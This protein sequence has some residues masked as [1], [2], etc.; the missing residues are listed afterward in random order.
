MIPITYIR[1][2]SLKTYLDCGLRFF[3]DFNL[4]LKWPSGP[5]AILGSI[6]HEVQEIL[7][8]CKILQQS[9]TRDP[10]DNKFHFTDANKGIELVF[11]DI[12]E[13]DIE[14]LSKDI[15]DRWCSYIDPSRIPKSYSKIERW[16]PFK[17]V[18]DSLKNII[19]MSPRSFDIRS[20]DVYAVEKRFNYVIPDEWARY[21]F[22]FRNKQHIGQL[23]IKGSIDLIIKGPD[24]KYE[25]IDWKSGSAINFST[26]QEKSYDDYCND[27]QLQLYYLAAK[28][29]LGLDVSQ[30]TIVYP[31]EK[32]VGGR[33][34][35]GKSFSIVFENDNDIIN[36]VRSIYED[37]QSANRP[38]RVNSDFCIK[39]CPYCKNT[40][41]AVESKPLIKA[42]EYLWQPEGQEP[43]K[44]TYKICGQL[45]KY[46]DVG[47]SP[48]QVMECLSRDSFNIGAYVNS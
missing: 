47:F 4:G 29:V 41:D 30:V 46:F 18:Q 7:G 20:M 38:K 16:I 13:I 48:L 14:K 40:F 31:N 3:A 10:K 5:A 21:D 37:M 43:E 6:F 23:S 11:N 15:Y 27:I 39:Y 42:R 12:Y 36:T 9:G 8:L 26:G 2:S 32:V 22:I 25:I 34:T 17:K 28:R 1:S 33:Y 44:K 35:T 24:N 19:E 45:S